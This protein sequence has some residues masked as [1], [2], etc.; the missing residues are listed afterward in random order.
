M[1]MLKLR[2]RL[3]LNHPPM[4][5]LMLI[6]KTKEMIVALKEE[7]LN[8]NQLWRLIKEKEVSLL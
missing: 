2:V 8:L 3:H 6:G 4:Q 5:F 7:Q 1:L